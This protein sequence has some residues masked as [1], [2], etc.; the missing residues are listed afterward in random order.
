MRNESRPPP[1]HVFD[2]GR[3]KFHLF[4]YEWMSFFIFSIFRSAA[5]GMHMTPA[6]VSLFFLA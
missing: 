2:D 5:L 4:H 3:A 6:S 1:F